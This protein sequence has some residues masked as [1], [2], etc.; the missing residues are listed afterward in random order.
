MLLIYY[1]IIKTP[2]LTE[3]ATY[4]YINTCFEYPTPHTCN[5]HQ[6]M[7]TGNIQ[8]NICKKRKLVV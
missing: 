8:I 7:R 1:K 2:D 3:D 5:Y 6:T 4:Y